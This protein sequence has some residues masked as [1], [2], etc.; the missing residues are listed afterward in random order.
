MPNAQN[1]FLHHTWY[2]T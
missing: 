1:T 2:V